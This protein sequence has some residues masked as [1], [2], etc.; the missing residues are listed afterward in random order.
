MP[1]RPAYPYMAVHAPQDVHAFQVAPRCFV[2]SAARRW[3][4]EACRVVSCRG[5]GSLSECLQRLGCSSFSGRA[6]STVAG[7]WRAL[8][9]P[10]F[11]MENTGTSLRQVLRPL[12]STSRSLAEVPASL[13][14]PIEPTGKDFRIVARCAAADAAPLR[15]CMCPS[16]WCSPAPCPVRANASAVPSLQ[17]VLLPGHQ[18]RRGPSLSRPQARHPHSKLRLFEAP[19][20]A[21]TKAVLDRTGGTEYPRYPIPGWRAGPRHV[22]AYFR[23]WERCKLLPCPVKILTRHPGRWPM[24]TTG[25]TWPRPVSGIG[26]PLAG[27]GTLPYPP[28]VLLGRHSNPNPPSSDQP[29]LASHLS[30]PSSLTPSPSFSV[31]SPTLLRL[32]R[33]TTHRCATRAFESS[34]HSPFDTPDAPI[35]W[36]CARPLDE[37]ARRVAGSPPPQQRHRSSFRA[38]RRQFLAAHSL[39]ICRARSVDDISTANQQASVACLL[40]ASYLSVPHTSC[41]RRT[42]DR[43]SPRTIAPTPALQIYPFLCVNHYHHRPS[44]YSTDRGF[45]RRR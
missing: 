1:A 41:R 23:R 40:Q 34:S 44:R 39:L 24:G 42:Q 33:H 12:P 19:P 4:G 27:Q 3:R 15:C 38:R 30:H 16:P 37:F 10:R 26:Y 9:L 7:R 21:G 31:P 8:A 29:A 14:M 28:P 20:E 6:G 43:T 11:E 5:P 36:C 22:R 18:T 25:G 45:T 17:T 2:K 32:L 13:P 35:P